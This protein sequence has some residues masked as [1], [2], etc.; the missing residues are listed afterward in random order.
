MQSHDNTNTIISTNQPSTPTN[1]PIVPAFPVLPISTRSTT[2]AE[3]G[4]AYP[5]VDLTA[6]ILPQFR[7]ANAKRRLFFPQPHFGGCKETEYHKNHKDDDDYSKT[8]PTLA[9]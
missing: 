7:S 4:T 6:L 8:H 9:C 5:R 3:V 2:R 1:Q